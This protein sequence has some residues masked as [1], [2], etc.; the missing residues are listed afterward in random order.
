MSR[1]NALRIINLNYNNNTIKV[2]DEIFDFASESTLMSLRNGGGKTVLVQMMMAPFVSK[3]NR[4]LKD[5]KF[6]SYFQNSPTYILTEWQLDDNG[7]YLL[8][9]MAVKKRSMASDEDSADEL[10]IFTFIHHYAQKSKYDIYNVPI[11]EI[12]KDGQKTVKGYQSLRTE[13]EAARKAL[14]DPL[15]VYNMNAYEQSKKYFQKLKEYKIDSRE[16][17]IIHKINLKESGLSELFS[18]AKNVEGL[19]ER[20]FLS[21]V[22]DKLNKAGNKIKEFNEIV[23]KYIFQYREIQSKIE[24]KDTIELFCNE[25]E[26]L[27]KYTLDLAEK[28]KKLEDKRNRVANFIKYL[29]KI[30][31]EKESEA[32]S[33]KGKIEECD[34]SINDLKYQELSKDWYH[35]YDEIDKINNLLNELEE[36]KEK[37]EEQKSALHKQLHIYE[38]A[39][40]K[41]EY[42]ENHKELR[43]IESELQNIDKTEEEKAPE[44]NNLG[45]SLRL[46]YEKELVKMQ[47]KLETINE[48]ISELKE[49]IEKSKANDEALRDDYTSKVSNKAKLEA[50]I[51]V[52]EE[53]EGN[54][55]KKSGTMLTRNILG[56]FDDG[57]LENIENNIGKEI[58]QCKQ[59]TENTKKNID[60]L[61]DNIGLKNREQQ[62]LFRSEIEL[63]NNVEKYEEEKS[64][65]KNEITLRKNLLRILNMSNEEIYNKDLIIENIGNKIQAAETRGG[66]LAVEKSRLENEKSKLERG[67]LTE[68]PS[69]LKDK[70]DELDIDF[71]YGMEW[72]NKNNR[73]KE[74]NQ[75]IIKD[76]PFLPYA[77]ILNEDDI[78]KIQKNDLKEFTSNPIPIIKKSSIFDEVHSTNNMCSFDNI[79]FYISFDKRLVDKTELNIIIEEKSNEINKIDQKISMNNADKNDYSDKL[80]KV[81]E[82]TVTQGLYNEASDKINDVKN[83]ITEVKDKVTR[84]E[85]LIK[86]LAN[87]IQEAGEKYN[88]YVKKYLE[89]KNNMESFMELKAKY[90]IYS[91]NKIKLAETIKEIGNIKIRIDENSDNLDQLSDWLKNEENHLS[92]TRAEIEKTDKEYLKFS[93]YKEGQSVNRDFEVIRSEYDALTSKISADRA[94]LEK[95]KG[96]FEDKFQKSQ[97]KLLE[98]KEEY[99]LEE[100]EFTNIK[101]DK[102]KHK[103]IKRKF[104]YASE[105]L[106]NQI[107]EIHSQELE[108]TKVNSSLQ[109]IEKNIYEKFSLDRPKEKDSIMDV[110]FK[111]EIKLKLIEKDK[112]EKSLNQCYLQYNKINENI[113][114][115]DGYK[116]LGITE[117]Q[118]IDIEID[119]LD[120]HRN[121]YINF[122]EQCSGEVEKSRKETEGKLDNIASDVRLKSEVMVSSSLRTVRDCVSVTKNLLEQISIVLNSCQTMIGK[123][124]VDIDYIYKDEEEVLSILNEYLKEVH[125]NLGMI[126][127]NSS[128]NIKGKNV[129][130]LKIKLPDWEL[131]KEAYKNSLRFIL[132][133]LRD[134][135]LNKLSQNESIEELIS[136]TIS[137][138][139]LYNNTVGISNI[140]VKL[141]KIEENRQT[142]IS[143]NNVSTNSGGE[144]FLSAFVILSSLLT[145]MRKDE[146]DIFSSNKDSKVIVMDNPFAQTNAAH[147]LK[148][149][150]NIAE[151]S[152]TQ[153]I[154]FTG[155]GG[156]SIYNRFNNIYVL[157][158]KQSKLKS[159]QQ[160]LKYTHEKGENLV[161]E[162]QSSRF[163]IE[164]K[165]IEQMV[166]F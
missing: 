81:S 106:E 146:T 23:K 42:D 21:T 125:N 84:N 117:N 38:C 145:Y 64:K 149:L 24:K 104:D 153:L 99:N 107:K 121:N 44:R 43:E 1:I 11:I 128:V 95:M 116:G 8:V 147:L 159:N 123:L 113:L 65:Y 27:T 140:D 68:I 103:E 18:D 19:V 96:S 154:C 150:M 20:W 162:I 90:Y 72:L 45:Y 101:Y 74:D 55:E 152:R 129:K 49:S 30:K 52:Y 73:S 91:E 160:Y 166:L 108:R 62:N 63:A 163:K 122:I 61:N 10:D 86:E 126:D 77:L 37:T 114:K 48:K 46:F 58:E 165:S 156:E 80:N 16:W 50:L 53:E 138:N 75:E 158:T 40:L 134:S 97:N 29:N 93:Q 105:I 13:L 17:D 164:E 57:Y 139:Y 70:L 32:D 26:D 143:W 98:K 112:L 25:L 5:R 89:L 71:L 28:E 33:V 76:N 157:E 14:K 110:N 131:N 85:S 60:I 132:E 142:E 100:S 3:R 161:S 78:I 36:T 102:F 66:F 130:M 12:K 39:E 15:E 119:K 31:T 135:C 92:D 47:E 54:Y 4:D 115:L 9:G 148:P 51:R 22:E 7:G 120:E 151:K 144:G 35:C 133:K 59:D 2:D 141:Y 82:T 6:K 109:N 127:D 34:N 137:I 69:K 79:S 88:S 83:K 136:K 118:D 94:R 41:E 155:L 67:I 56:V 87:K 124:Q 111:A